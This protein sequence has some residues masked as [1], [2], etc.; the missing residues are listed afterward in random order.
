MVK[1][2]IFD[3]GG[4]IVRTE[5][6]G[7]R[8]TWDERLGLAPGSVERAVHGSDLWVQAQLGRI[9]TERYWRGVAELV[10][11][12]DPRR[13][14]QLRVD[15]YSGDY[16]NHRLMG[17]IKDLREAGC[18]TALLSN[19]SLE[20]LPR[21]EQLE[22]ESLFDHIFVSAQLGVMKPD[23]TAYRVALQRLRVKPADAIFIDDMLTNVRGA[24]SIG[25]PAI[26]YRPET[27]VR[28][29]LRPHF[30]SGVL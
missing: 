4:V 3:F 8:R 6:Y 29:E 23:P 10:Y 11:M 13:I 5:D 7:P 30:D 16:L 18:V 2:V 25:L 12:R 15:Y 9:T 26:L 27:D 28:A 24:Q 21:L 14:D 19:D 17:V 22:I 20:L 1:A